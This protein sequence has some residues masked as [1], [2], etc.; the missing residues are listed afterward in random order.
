ME[1]FDKGNYRSDLDLR[2]VLS[3]KNVPSEVIDK[4][5]ESWR[6]Y[7]TSLNKN[8]TDIFSSYLEIGNKN[9]LG[10]LFSALYEDGKTGQSEGLLINSHLLTTL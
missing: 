5:I 4:Y 8:I 1:E 2:E 9:D 10:K 3:E 6:E 7:I